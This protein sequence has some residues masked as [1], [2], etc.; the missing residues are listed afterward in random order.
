[1]THDSPTASLNVLITG[2]S[3]GIGERTA[4]HLAR[5]GHAV[6]ATM[7][8]VSKGARLSEAA[9]SENLDIRVVPLDIAD[10][11]SVS[12]GVRE[13]LALTGGCLDAVVNNAG[14]SIQGPA[15]EW[16]DDEILSLLDAN[17]VGHTR[18]TRE[19]LPVMREAGSGVIVNVTSTLGLQVLPY[20]N[21]YCA[22]KHAF[23]A[24]SES[25]AY[26][27]EPF[28]IRVRI[29]APGAYATAIVGNTRHVAAHDESSP[30][31]ET[32]QR[33]STLVNAGI[34]AGGDPTEVADAIER[35]IVDPTCPLRTLVPST[36]NAQ[37]SA[38]RSTP[39]EQWMAAVR[40]NL[41]I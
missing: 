17:F 37:L 35:A 22:S 1:M 30:Y 32:F 31:R 26:E 24:Y 3:S 33:V 11:A 10:P 6:I 21:V 23:D 20:A 19:V 25:L 28:G 16:N 12:A 5:K 29:I 8:D 18:V 15:E 39:D 41:G 4:L 38:R 9:A 13:A 2:C 27:V 36:A 34:E 40:T 7:R 14:T